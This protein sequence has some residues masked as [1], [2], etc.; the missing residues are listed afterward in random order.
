MS[1]TS[2]PTGRASHPDH[3]AGTPETSAETPAESQATSPLALTPEEIA[4]TAQALHGM[5]FGTEGLTRDEL[6]ARYHD[7]PKPVYLR[8]PSSKH[9]IN[10]LEVLQE[11]EIAPSRAEGEFIGANPNLPEAES[12]ADGGPPLWGPTS[13]FTP[14]GVVEGGSMEDTEGLEEDE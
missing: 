3:S 10:A 6:R 9:F 1:A 4:A 11:A 2:D 7:L 8:L 5:D 13:L 12:I 14:G